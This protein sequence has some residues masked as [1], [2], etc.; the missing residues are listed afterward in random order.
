M[1]VEVQRI[2]EV[3]AALAKTRAIVHLDRALNHF[4]GRLTA[5]LAEVTPEPPEHSE[6][7]IAALHRPMPRSLYLLPPWGI[8]THRPATNDR[9]KPLYDIC[10]CHHD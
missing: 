6:N 9:V 10:V 8:R 7:V 5:T 4:C 2:S 3:V 1:Y